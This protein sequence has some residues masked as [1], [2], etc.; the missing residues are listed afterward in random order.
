[1]G[2]VYLRS[3]VTALLFISTAICLAV[4][5]AVADEPHV[6]FVQGLRDRGYYDFALLYL[7][8]L[9]S[10]NDIP[11]EVK[12]VITFERAITL[13]ANS[14]LLKNPDAQAKQ[15]DAA[16]ANL[17]QFTK[18]SPN[19]PRSA[20]A[21]TEQ[22]RIL[23]GKARV[24]IWKANSPANEDSKDQL[25]QDARA[26]VVQAR[27]VFQAAFDRYQAAWKKF[28]TFI[29]DDEKQ[30]RREREEA[31][32]MLMRTKLDLANCTY[33]EAQTYNR[34]SKEYKD[35]LNK[36]SL[37]YDAIHTEYRSQVAGLFA[38][39]MMGKC[40]EE[41]D[42]LRKALGIYDELLRHPGQSPVLK[43]L[44]AQALHFRLICLNHEQRKDYLLAI[45]EAEE[46]LKEAKSKART[47]T[48]LGIRWE[49]AR[50]QELLSQ[51]REVSET[52]KNRILRQALTN[53]RDINR[54]PGKYQDV[55]YSMIQRLLVALNREPGDPQDFDTAFGTANKMLEEIGGLRTKIETAEAKGQ[56][57]EVKKLNDELDALLAEAERMWKLALQL[58]TDETELTQ[59]NLARYRLAFVLYLRKKSYDAAVVGE[60][61]ATHFQKETPTLAL[62]AAYIAL[63]GYTQAYNQAEKSRK[64]VNLQLM[65]GVAKTIIEGWPKTARANDAR[66][67]MGQVL[68][69]ADKPVEAAKWYSEV[70]ESSERYGDAQLEAGQSY[71]NA[72]LIGVSADDGPTSEELTNWQTEAMQRLSAGIATIGK[73]IPE[74]TA[75][76]DSLVRAKA[77]L[78][79]IKILTASDN[80]AI[81]ILTKE[82]HSVVKAIE[83]PDE[84]KRSKSPSDIK[85][86]A[87]ALFVNQLLLRAYVGTKQ[88][89]K[90][91]EVRKAL[92]KIAGAD[93]GEGL[94]AVY[95]EL[96]RELQNELEQLKRVNND[97]R[98]KEVRSAF[99]AFLE[100]LFKQKTGQTYGSL[101]WIAE[102][103]YGLAQGSEGED[104][105][106]SKYYG[107]A[108]T[109]YEDILSRA[110][111]DSQFVDP[112]RL[113]G[114]RLRLVNCKRREGDFERAETLITE[115][116][117]EKPKVLDAQMEAA[118]VYQEW[119]TTDSLQ[120][121]KLK[122]AI[123]GKKDGT[124]VWGWNQIAN[125][126][127]LIIEGGQGTV[128]YQEKYYEARY[129]L[130]KSRFDYAN[131]L[132]DTEQKN[133]E[134]NKAEY[135]LVAFSRITPDLAETEWW[136]KF[137]NVYQDIQVGLGRTPIPLEKPEKIVVVSTDLTGNEIA[138]NGGS[139]GNE[140][141][142]E[143]VEEGGTKKKES[144]G[145]IMTTLM[146]IGVLLI[147]LG[148]VA[149]FVMNGNKKQ[150]P[151]VASQAL[152]DVLPTPAAMP[153]RSSKPATAKTGQKPKPKTRRPASPAAEG[154]KPA[155][156]EGK[157]Q[158]AKVRKKR[159]VDPSAGTGEKKPRPE[160]PGQPKKPR[161]KPES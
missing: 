41:Q 59:V 85:G 14:R 109:T 96:G 126:L 36:A 111:G 52:D 39:L 92:E 61:L 56:K 88:L 139:A 145:G 43:D 137:D 158:A 78:A 42:D 53:A 138:N 150:K 114:V 54:F 119:G 31:E 57:E 48:G 83:V 30:K 140:G 66:M 136:N 7:D 68:R 13:L 80:E 79:Q 45:S 63:A 107:N 9:E 125:R 18:A 149:V 134:L 143:K 103:Y 70:P 84:S 33:E 93:G 62:D 160:N 118:R 99:E 74:M 94:T 1:M 133:K 29:P 146:V 157:P 98:L 16:L 15:L 91:R 115:V 110:Q 81:D 5:N 82:P 20:Q 130:S 147:G 64:E 100:D 12:E 24:L 44:Q 23:L 135:E 108:A 121:E 17:E 72:Y 122:T 58:V 76:P 27:N 22:A 153:R 142:P 73:T 32:R 123:D 148:L 141:D 151:V 4:G 155:T 113:P 67:M 25:Q 10:R 8:Q 159:P 21:N 71:W 104:A 129:N 154:K 51:K 65:T 102:T 127:Q 144:S 101:I 50:S 28:P 106:A 60:F 55:S 120:S 117:S 47:Q 40:F 26:L 3:R 38:H 77:S 2:C 90:A 35:V 132:S 11:Q 105:A 112:K 152:P 75:A 97:K 131:S 128:E 6:E 37:E 87:F 95:V 89:E 19:H 49:L 86:R 116:L 34:E 69:Q 124:P 161:P 46:W 156:S